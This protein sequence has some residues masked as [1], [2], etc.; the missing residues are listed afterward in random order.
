MPHVTRNLVAVTGRKP[1]MGKNGQK[2]EKVAQGPTL[3]KMAQKRRKTGI[4]GHLSFFLLFLGHFFPLSGPG[5][6]PI[7]RRISFH[8][9]LSARFPFDAR[10]TNSQVKLENSGNSL[11][12]RPHVTTQS[13]HLP[14][15]LVAQ[16]RACSGGT[17]ATFH[18]ANGS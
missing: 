4:L 3:E 6:F 5:P 17:V 13:W 16:C 1:K 12:C 18:I 9:C 15:S 7:F 11:H 10:Q 8:F 14:K 2:I